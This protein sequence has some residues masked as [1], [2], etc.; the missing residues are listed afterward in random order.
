MT[1]F[2]SDSERPGPEQE[3]EQKDSEKQNPE[4]LAPVQGTEASEQD[5]KREDS[6]EQNPEQSASEKET[7]PDRQTLPGCRL[8]EEQNR[9]G[10]RVVDEACL[11]MKSTRVQ[12]AE[13]DSPP[14]ISTKNRQADLIAD[15]PK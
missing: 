9:C 12:N 4:Q 7:F 15:N 2:V 3:S 6:E 10:Y 8:D 11:R 13:A 14:S 1:C 5:S